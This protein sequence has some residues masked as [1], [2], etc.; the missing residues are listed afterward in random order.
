MSGM[1]QFFDPII[2]GVIIGA[3]ATILYLFNGKI[4]GISGITRASLSLDG[5]DKSWRYFFIA[6]LFLGGLGLLFMNP[7]LIKAPEEKSFLTLAAAGLLVGYGTAL[8]NGCTSGHGIC[9]LSRFSLRSLFATLS[10]M[11]SGFLIASLAGVFS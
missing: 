3:A 10:F 8:G 2:G 11:F 5:E 1:Q 4:A 6:G 9:G 7:D